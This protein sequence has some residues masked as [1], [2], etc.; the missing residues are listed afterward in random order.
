VQDSSRV[1]SF[2][3]GAGGRLATM[4]DAS[5]FV[6]TYQYDADGRTLKVGYTRTKSDG[7][8]VTE[9]QATRYD[10]AG[11]AVFNAVASWNGSAWSFG[12][13]SHSNTVTGACVTHVNQWGIVLLSPYYVPVLHPPYYTPGDLRQEDGRRRPRAETSLGGA[14]IG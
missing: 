8:S 9:A 3:Y 11:R 4:T 6:R 13:S 14:V 2:T 12:D 10:A 7:T 1:T 5:G